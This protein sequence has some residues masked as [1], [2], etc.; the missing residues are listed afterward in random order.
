MNRTGTAVLCALC[1]AL[2]AH[3]AAQAK[4]APLQEIGVEE[5]LGAHLPLDLELRDSRGSPV[6]LAEL[7]A[8]S[9]PTLLTLAY[10]HCPMLCSLVLGKVVS[11]VRELGWTPGKEYRLLTVSFDENDRPEDARRKRNA[12]LAAAG[13]AEKEAPWPFLVASRP[14]IAA[15]ADRLGFR[16]WRDP[17]TGEIAHPSVV[18]VLTPEGK[19][20][21]YLYGLDYS[22]RDAKLALL[23]ASEGR[24]GSSLD[25]M[26]L[27]CFRYD[28]A[29][30]RYGP[31]IFGFLR[32]GALAIFAALAAGLGA[33]WLRN[34][35]RR[36]A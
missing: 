34:R 22:A 4:L 17:R 11:T 12:V 26:L 14:A 18:F 21:R 32:I 6:R 9:Q 10:Y 13:L 30:R 1:V 8:G 25:R 35:R 3:A 31:Y 28:P 2:P 16:F 27:A 24:T 23:E 36:R 15:L 33:L 5:H 19:I 7:L 20:S 29:T